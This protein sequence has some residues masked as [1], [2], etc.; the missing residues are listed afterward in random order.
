[1]L[2]DVGA[3]VPA[4]ALRRIG[5]Y[6]GADPRFAT[7]VDLESHMRR[8][9]APFGPLSD[10]EWRH[11]ALHSAKQHADGSW[12]FIYDP[13]IGEPFRKGFF[14]DIDLWQVY[15]K[16]KCR[17]LVIRGAES[18]LLLERT[19]EEMTT[20][21]PKAKLVEFLGIGHAPMLMVADQIKTVKDFLLAP[22]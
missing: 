11:L 10:S 21:G 20:R 4:A 3:V 17:T 16:I 9:S 18:D 6:V 15:D 12:G 13:A 14:A 22:D 7:F 5:Q 8:Y 1:V 19:A 2:N